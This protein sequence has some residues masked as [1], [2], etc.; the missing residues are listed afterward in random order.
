MSIKVLGIDI[1]K[2]VFQLHGVDAIGK[3]VLK[4]RLSRNQLS[5]LISN[6]PQCCIVMEACGGANYWAR[7]FRRSGH[8]VKLISPQFGLLLRQIKMMRMMLRRL[9]KLRAGPR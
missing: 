1:A 7:V 9:P 2:T 8:S 5:L 4:K 3:V 6:L